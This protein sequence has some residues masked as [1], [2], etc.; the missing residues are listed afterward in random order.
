MR[1]LA[2]VLLAS[3][4]P[5]A[6]SAQTPMPPQPP[7]PT[8]QPQQQPPPMAPPPPSRVFWGGGLGFGFGDVDWVEV[9][10][11][12][13]YRVHPKIDL[14]LALTYRWRSDD[15][16]DLDTNDYG[17]TLFGRYRAWRNLFLE[18]DWEYLNWEYVRFD[19]STERTN[20]SSFLAGGGYYQP[21]GGRASMAV[22]ALYNFSY[23]DND[24]LEPYGEPWVLRFGIGVGF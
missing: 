3:F 18:A 23:D 6:A 17:G 24:P 22:S 10:P 4:L 2:T 13:G 7:P 21:L 9:S 1:T 11:L 20:T 19:L 12:V 16:F 14:G 8:P 15:R 5:L